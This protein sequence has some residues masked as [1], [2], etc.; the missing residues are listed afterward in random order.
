VRS[1]LILALAACLWLPAAV[2][3]Q[4]ESD[5]EATPPAEDTAA[6]VVEPALQLP[7]KPPMV[8][9]PGSSAFRFVQ[10]RGTGFDAWASQR[11]V[12]RLVDETGAAQIQWNSVWVSP[13]G[14]LTLEVNLC[15]DPFRGRPALAA[16]TYTLA[17]APAIGGAIATTNID[18][19]APPEAPEPET[20]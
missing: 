19:L 11:L 14:K 10:V 13:Q 17:V 20:P 7:N 4:A 12:G 2:F 15:A 8:C 9:D 3:A 18:L 1:I 6:P 16:G 5:A